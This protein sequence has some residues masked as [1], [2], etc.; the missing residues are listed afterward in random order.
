MKLA[1]HQPNYAPWCGYF[2]K[3][4]HCD[5][6]VFLDDVQMPGGQSYVYRTLIRWEGKP[7]WL[8][9]PTSFHLGD[10][11]NTVQFADGK[12]SKKHLS[13]F[14]ACYGRAPYFKEAMSLIGPLYEC[15]G[16]LLG[17][18]NC[19]LIIAVAKYLGLSCDF[20][21]SSRLKAEGHGDE[22]LISLAK[23]LGASKYLS[24]K[25]GQNY[26]SPAKFV[27]AGIDLQVNNYIPIPYAQGIGGFI[28]GLSVLDA[29]FHL[30][31][32][33]MSLLKYTTVGE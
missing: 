12:W 16:V 11:I 17:E 2:T 9:V 6:F 3:M 14:H 25:G 30:G 26:Q 21:L 7:R 27:A 28:P 31:K 15:P 20:H 33:T 13:T 19:R 18:F 24:G 29:L 1:V 23:R 10:P 5:F 32:E 4:R 22:R 8:S